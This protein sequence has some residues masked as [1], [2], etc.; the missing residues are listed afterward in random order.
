MLNEHDPSRY[1]RT[2]SKARFAVAK[3]YGMGSEGE[4][5]VEDIAEEL[6]VQPRQVYYY[7]NE[8]DIGKQ[9]KEVLATTQ[10]EWRLDMA[11]ELRKEV[12][13]L[14]HIEEELLQR[15][16]AV[17][18]DYDIK[19]VRGTPTGDRN[20]RLPEHA[21]EY[22]L[23]LP[24]PTDFETVTDYSGDLES[25]QEQKRKYISEIADLLG[26][27]AADKKEV[28]HTLESRHEEVKVVNIRET[29]DNYPQTQPLNMEESDADELNAAGD[30]VD[31]E[32]VEEAPE[33]GEEE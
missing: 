6:D 8:T 1:Q 32:A 12:Q 25:V 9:T 18:T 2:G 15:E 4:W 16:K 21:D 7:L 29:E 13:R 22:E 26:L 3:Y 30:V 28:D 27:D 17:A 19:T 14:E 23:E 10:A 11:L 20:I 24:V 33:S 31:V 5:D